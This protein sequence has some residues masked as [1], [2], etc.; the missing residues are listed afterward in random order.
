M[1]K[2]VGVS[3]GLYL[4]LKEFAQSRGATLSS[5][6]GL[7]LYAYMGLD[8]KPKLTAKPLTPVSD[9][10]ARRKTE[11]EAELEALAIWER[12]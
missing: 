12:E 3:D 2:L 9:A 10:E 11:R 6:V 4:E 8:K 5:V 7:A 1:T